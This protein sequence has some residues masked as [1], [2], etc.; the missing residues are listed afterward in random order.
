VS[1][2]KY[3]VYE[4]LHK[5][6]LKKRIAEL[7]GLCGVNV[8][9]PSPGDLERVYNAY[10]SERAKGKEALALLRECREVFSPSDGY[11]KYE[12]FRAIIEKIEKFLEGKGIAHTKS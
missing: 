3:A 7:D 5:E 11:I 2:N 1:K 10:L 4:L 12:E 9:E 6:Q 8:N